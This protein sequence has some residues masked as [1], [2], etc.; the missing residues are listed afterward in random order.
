[1]TDRENLFRL[2]KLKDELLDKQLECHTF[3]KEVSQTIVL[4]NSQEILLNQAYNDLHQQLEQKI[5][6]NVD[7]L[8]SVKKTQDNLN[9]KIDKQ[10]LHKVNE[11]QRVAEILV[12]QEAKRVATND[13]LLFGL[14]ELN[15]LKET[16]AMLN[17][18]EADIRVLCAKR[19]RQLNEAIVFS[20]LRRDI[21]EFEMWI[22]EKTRHARNLSLN[23]SSSSANA[24]PLS[25][26]A[27]LNDKVKLFQKQKALF[28]DI[29]ANKSRYQDL[30][31]RGQEQI[32]SNTTVRTEQIKQSV[33][34]L[35]RKWRDLE[36]ESRERAK[37]FEEAKDILEF[38]DQLERLEDWLKEKELM[39]QNG[40]TGRDYEHCVALI[41][42]A[43]EAVSPQNEQKLQAVLHMGDKLV[44]MGRTDRD[45]VLANKNRL[46][47]RSKFIKTG[48][49]EY[50]NRL[51]IAL[52]IHVFMR[53]YEDIQQ[54]IGEKRKL[55]TT[56]TD[57][58][59]TLDAVQVAQKKLV[60]IEGNLKGIY[61]LFFVI[62]YK[63]YTVENIVSV[64]KCY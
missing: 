49:E 47:E 2:W 23:Q 45:L 62:K 39:L 59:R 36:Y 28:S 34:D 58:L 61:L 13:Q 3:Y 15:R 20:K 1:M 16:L 26:T 63:V 43:E 60:D 44:R 40:D 41:K 27:L 8:E 17:K 35:V 4:I 38:N 18:K 12:D 25:S 53:D 46:L 57:M 24:S 51:H 29:E 14:N 42:K 6:F 50:K 54:R 33:D 11:L 37:E 9:K 30:T 22:D 64:N 31:H 56:D 52:E 7:D 55:L 48:V 21:D 32:R 10:T 19:C 5:L